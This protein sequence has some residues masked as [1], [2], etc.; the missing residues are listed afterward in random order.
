[1]GHFGRVR[2]PVAGALLA[3]GGLI[4]GSVALA[5]CGPTPLAQAGSVLRTATDA[6]IVHPDGSR[7]SAQAGESLQRGDE[8]LTAKGGSATVDTRARMVRLVGGSALTVLRGDRQVLQRGQAVIDAQAGDGETVE[9]DGYTVTVP[10]GSA[11]R[12]QRGSNFSAG[13]LAGST[14]V[15]NADGARLTVPALSQV[16]FGGDALPTAAT[17][18]HLTDDAAEAATVPSLVR[19][20]E[21]L[22]SLARGIDG[23]GRSATGAVD[24]AWQ[25]GGGASPGAAGRDTA[26]SDR[27]LPIVIARSA[28]HQSANSAYRDAVGWRAQGG[29]WGVI[30]HRL[31]VG[32]V[33]VST[34]LAA[35]ERVTHG[36]LG[37]AGLAALVGAATGVPVKAPQGVTP[38]HKQSAG[39]PPTAPPPTSTPPTPP[40]PTP[41][42][43]PKPSG[44]PVGSVVSTVK[45]VLQHLPKLPPSVPALPLPAPSLP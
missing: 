32:A 14:T 41:T 27:V 5:G 29:S 15:T 16:V 18:L 6:T 34:E 30:T 36:R 28:R 25:S 37:R 39:G 24:A 4:A 19:D 17:A 3:V 45:Q 8:I 11:T 23:A 35:L 26:I 21:Q 31:G 13:V 42:P 43:S 22:N 33:A 1:M 38:G 20:D 12:V 44:G 2:R 9:L 40:T 7:S 10:S